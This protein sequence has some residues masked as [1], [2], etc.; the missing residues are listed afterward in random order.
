MII[1]Q[2][3]RGKKGEFTWNLSISLKK[4]LKKNPIRMFWIKTFFFNDSID[5]KKKKKNKHL[6]KFNESFKKKNR[7]NLKISDVNTFFVIFLIMCLC[8]NMYRKIHL[9]YSFWPSIEK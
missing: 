7:A 3:L 1:E 9:N 5:E 8:F 4:K 6:F 2:H